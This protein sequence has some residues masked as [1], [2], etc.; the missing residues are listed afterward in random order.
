LKVRVSKGEARRLLSA[1][2]EVDRDRARRALAIFDGQRV[3]VARCELAEQRQRIVI[4]DEAHGLARGQRIQRA[5][6]GSVPKA[7]GDAAR[8][9]R[10]DGIRGKVGVSLGHEEGLSGQVVAGRFNG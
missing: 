8:V 6:D 7:L 5:E 1:L 9:E 10:V 4:V 3:A 2:D